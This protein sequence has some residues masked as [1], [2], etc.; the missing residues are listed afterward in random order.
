MQAAEILNE[1]TVFEHDCQD[2]LVQ[3][4][5]G[6]FVCMRCGKVDPEAASRFAHENGIVNGGTF[7][8][9]DHNAGN[10]LF[11]SQTV[12][13]GYVSRKNPGVAMELNNHYGK[14]AHGK[15][16][17]PQ[18]HDAYKAGLVADPSKGCHV[19]EDPLTGKSEVKFSHYDRPTL[20]I[21]KER[22]LKK[23]KEYRLDVVK[24]TLIAKDLKTIYSRLFMGPLVDYAVLAT[25]LH[26]RH[27]LPK[28]VIPEL[29]KE[30][31][32]CIEEIRRK[33]VSG[34]APKVKD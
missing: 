11:E 27:F 13:A 19:E 17:V 22:A 21:I 26:H 5:E 6:E 20:Q 9:E 24:Q 33:V 12:Q 8:A 30:M 31:A 4:F 34:C 3:T 29:E 25:L 23:C 15:R 28:S 2:N 14:D 7:T 16:I 10:G 32:L 18:L 1:Q